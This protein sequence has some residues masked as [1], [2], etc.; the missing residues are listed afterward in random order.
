MFTQWTVFAKGSLH[1]PYEI[2]HLE[3]GFCNEDLSRQP[4]R[5][6]YILN[7]RNAKK[8]THDT[9]VVYSSDVQDLV[10]RGWRRD[11]KN[12][13]RTPPSCVQ[14][15]FKTSILTGT[16]YRNVLGYSH[17]DKQEESETE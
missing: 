6:I 9:E 10:A 17:L 1:L 4:S 15:D 12:E 13:D 16:P 11:V 3:Y 5:F 8:Y 2:K 14:Q 7:K